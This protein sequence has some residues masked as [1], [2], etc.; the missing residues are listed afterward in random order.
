MNKVD[1]RIFKPALSV[2]KKTILNTTSFF[3][4]GVVWAAPRD[5]LHGHGLQLAPAPAQLQEEVQR[6]QVA[7]RLHTHQNTGREQCSTALIT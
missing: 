7:V 3:Q 6:A 5:V 1:I 4:G 2:N